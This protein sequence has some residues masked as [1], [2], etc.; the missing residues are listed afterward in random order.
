MGHPFTKGAVYRSPFFGS[1]H[2]IIH[3]LLERLKQC[4]ASCYPFENIDSGREMLYERSDMSTETNLVKDMIEYVIEKDYME[5]R[6]TGE[7]SEAIV[8]HSCL[9][10]CK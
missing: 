3:S 5:E 9:K 10:H 6:K 8:S 7:E 4:P 1:F 2:M